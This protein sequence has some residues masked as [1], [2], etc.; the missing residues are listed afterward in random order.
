MEVVL[1]LLPTTTGLAATFS[2]GADRT[3]A[4][5][6]SSTHSAAAYTTIEQKLTCCIK[7]DRGVRHRDPTNA[8]AAAADEYPPAAGLAWPPSPVPPPECSVCC[9]C[10]RRFLTTANHSFV[11]SII[12]RESWP[13]PPPG[14][15]RA[16]HL[17]AV[18]ESNETGC[19][20]TQAKQAMAGI[21]GAQNH[22]Y[23][24]PIRSIASPPADLRHQNGTAHPEER[25]ALRTVRTRG[26]E[27]PYATDQISAL[28]LHPIISVVRLSG[29]LSA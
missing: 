9:C 22:V 11:K 7:G 2:Y 1:L 13:S 6:E 3:Q 12:D 5:L 25:M 15:R 28:V 24:A 20:D 21:D 26:M 17:A 19:V 10:S 4:Y 29:T 27:A 16:A 23:L 8:S 18:E 14:G